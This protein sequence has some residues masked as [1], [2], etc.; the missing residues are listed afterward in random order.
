[1]SP[2]TGL[3]WAA[4]PAVSASVVGLYVGLSAQEPEKPKAKQKAKPKEK[5]EIT[6]PPKIGGDMEVVTDSSIDFL[7]PPKTL[8]EGVAVA[9]TPPKVDFLYF[10]GQTYEGKPWS[11]W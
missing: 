3:R 5:E 9:K 2:R 10:P 7:N 11:N 6:F 4:I 1:M 8:R